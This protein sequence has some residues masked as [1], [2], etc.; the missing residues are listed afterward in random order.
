MSQRDMWK[1]LHLLFKYAPDEGLDDQQLRMAGL[2][3][4]KDTID[5][6]YKSGAVLRDD[7]TRR[8]SLSPAATKILESTI[9]ANRRWAGDD[10]RVDYPYAFII[11]PFSEPWS[12]SVYERMIKSAVD[13]AGL[14]CYRGDASVRVGDLTQNIWN[15][16]LKAGLVIADV[17]ALNANVFYELG[18]AHAL[19]KDTFILKNKESKVPADFGGAHYYEYDGDRLEAG[20]DLLRA[21]I[22]NW[23][24]HE[25]V[26]ADGVKVLSE[27]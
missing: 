7:N 25:D 9:V 3:C 8:Y 24:R 5:P 17:S 14:E 27:M 20:R 1:M 4:Y 26:K 21:E 12:D 11:M 22:I 19:G 23:A 16:L 10:M 18:L 6:L 13:G 2:D 15:E